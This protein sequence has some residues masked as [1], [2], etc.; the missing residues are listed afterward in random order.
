MF[1][2]GT[3]SKYKDKSSLDNVGTCDITLALTGNPNV[4][5]STVFNA[6][7]GLNQH[8]GNW[9]GKTVSLAYGSYLS[10]GSKYKVI[11]LPGAYSLLSDSPEEKITY[12]YITGGEYDCIIIVADATALERNLFL[13]L[14]V[15]SNTNKAVLCL[16][17]C[18][19]A[20]KK[21]ISIDTDELSLQLG[22]PV[23][24]TTARSKKGIE[25]LKETTQNVAEGKLKTYTTP[26]INE[27]RSFERLSYEAY[28]EKISGICKEIASKVIG[29]A[30][31]VYS[32]KDKKL[33]RLFTSKLTGIPIM[34]L[35]FAVIFWITAYGA[36]YPSEWLSM[37][38][39]FIKAKLEILFTE[40]NF[41]ETVS[42]LLLDGIYTTTAWVVSVMLPPALIFFP[43]FA[44]L[45]DS[46]Y[47]PRVAFNL[48]RCF[49]RAGSN[50]KQALTMA[51]GFGCNACGVMGSRIINSKR[52]RILAIVT[53]SFIPC[54]G[55][56]P[57]LIGII[58]IFFATG[59]SGFT[60]S[61]IT[62]GTL[63]LLLILSVLLT[64]LVSFILSK[65]LLRGEPSSFI[66][67]LPPYRKPQIIKVTL[68]SVK[69]K[70]LYVLSRA[71]FVSIPAGALIWFVSNVSIND[72]TI[73]SYIT[74]FFAP[75][76]EVIGVDGVILT[77]FILGFPA[78]E[79]VIPIMLLSYM[80]SGEL[81]EYASLSQLGS[82]LASNGWTMLTAICTTVLCLLHFPC[83]T[84][85]FAIK[86]ETN[87]SFWTVMSVI[88][89]MVLGL[90][91]CFIITLLFRLFM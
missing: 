44:I 23:T 48:D 82:L 8:T 49:R 12:D 47:L 25:S 13:A 55:R 78:N 66:L 80:S 35:V 33:D 70:V 73:L 27:I 58:S 90:S 30:G 39:S 75:L 14:Q 88:I 26:A 77:A 53:N 29:K 57:T 50:G 17:L 5:K 22:I 28:T 89:P 52:E 3:I 86:K 21:G 60:K 79:I 15:L 85:C 42:S 9:A 68:L 67:E 40:L 18:D 76:G 87:S 65:T 2:I 38:F 56:L 69:E 20:K 41:S 62:T 81:T 59:V 34:L 51:M 6:L 1:Y 19:E 46:G 4:G 64:L 24:E 72:A 45:E 43:L 11:D 61:V 83:S 37:L 7:T 31:E 71:V 10:K 32:T 74:N 91:I 36:N 16:N 84:T 63:L 54:N